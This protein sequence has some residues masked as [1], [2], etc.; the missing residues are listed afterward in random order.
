MCELAADPACKACIHPARARQVEWLRARI[1]AVPVRLVFESALELMGCTQ[2]GTFQA[3]Q[4][5]LGEQYRHGPCPRMGALPTS[6][7]LRCAQKG[8]SAWPAMYMAGQCEVTCRSSPLFSERS[9]LRHSIPYD[10]AGG[11]I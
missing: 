2:I 11:C 3:R 10:L 8:M 1:Q 4:H 6:L 9:T 7:G 5:A